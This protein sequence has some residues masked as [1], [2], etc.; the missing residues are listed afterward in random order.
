MGANRSR[1]RGRL[2]FETRVPDTA[3]GVRDVR[4]AA[5]HAIPADANADTAELVI[6][7][8]VS[9]AV[10]HAGCPCLLGIYSWGPCLLIQVQD[11]SDD[12]P[13]TG[14]PL[15]SNLDGSGRGLQIVH[16]LSE[17]FGVQ[18]VRPTGKIVWAVVC[19]CDGEECAQDYESWMTSS[20]N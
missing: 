5:L 12:Q 2:L 4:H 17:S 19:L 9:N 6:A 10:A 13:V 16:A 18:Q 15:S 7:E 1:R 20:L 3:L 8:L 11:N 14:P